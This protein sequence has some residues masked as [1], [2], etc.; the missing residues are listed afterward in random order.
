MKLTSLL[1]GF[2]ACCAVNPAPNRRMIP[3]FFFLPFDAPPARSAF[4]PG[5]A[6]FRS[7]LPPMNFYLLDK[8]GKSDRPRKLNMSA[9]PPNLEDYI[10]R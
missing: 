8:Y 10:A 7:P 1:A 4:P 6:A 2:I 5:K 3:I 9:P